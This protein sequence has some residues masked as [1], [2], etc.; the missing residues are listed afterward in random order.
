MR[1]LLEIYC[2]WT[3]LP[4]ISL[5]DNRVKG[6]LDV[7]GCYGEEHQSGCNVF[8]RFFRIPTQFLFSKVAR[9]KT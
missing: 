4:L 2:K 9:E 5:A 6:L 3:E 1:Y 8:Y 7:C